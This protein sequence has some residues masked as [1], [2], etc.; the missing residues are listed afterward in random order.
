MSIKTILVHMAHDDRHMQRLEVALE[1]ARRFHAHLDIVYIATPVSM[2]A[3]ITGRGASYAY[4]AEATQIAHEKAVQVEQ[5]VR[6]LCQTL[7]YS[8]SLLEGDHVEL[9][10]ERA[11]F[12][13]LAVVSQSHPAHLED[14]VR[15]YLPDRLPMHAPCPTLVLPWDGRTRP[16][17]RHILVAWKNSRE[18][19]RAL[20]D[21]LPFLK[22]AERVTVLTIDRPGHSDMPGRDVLAYL[23]RHEVE[24][25]LRSNIHEGGS[26]VGEIILTVARDLGCDMAVMGAYGHARWREIVTGGTTRYV[27]GHMDLPVLMSH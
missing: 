11:A 2:P 16:H 10:A 27:L 21:A 12:A 23:H 3:H 9:L 25:E 7:G 20:R 8:W 13:D 6:Q 14:R 5:E 19:N 15:L 24:A 4:L 26:D 1:L 17:G 18:A 22:M